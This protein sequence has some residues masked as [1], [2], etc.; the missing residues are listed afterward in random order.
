MTVWL[1]PSP[2]PRTCSSPET[3]CSLKN[4][5]HRYHAPA[6]GNCC[7]VNH[8][9]VNAS[10]LGSSDRCLHTVSCFYSLL[11]SLSAMPLRLI[12]DPASARDN[13]LIKAK[14]YSIHLC[15]VWLMH[16]SL[17]NDLEL[18]PPS[19]Y[20]ILL[21]MIIGVQ[22]PNSGGVCTENYK[23]IRQFHVWFW[24]PSP[25]CFPRRALFL[26]GRQRCSSLLILS[27]QLG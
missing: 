21:P 18:L 25:H 9:L 19:G 7:S 14:R 5:S 2:V 11:V 22:T 26:P 15:Y 13:F 23:I 24:L 12:P 20:G 1:W 4:S 16:S 17:N 27:L 10:S 6:L 8:V 3:L